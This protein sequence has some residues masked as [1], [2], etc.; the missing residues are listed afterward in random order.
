MVTLALLGDTYPSQLQANPQAMRDLEVLWAGSSLETFRAKVPSLRPQVL[1]LDFVDLGKV[2]ERLVPELLSLTGAAHA[3]VSY[4]LTHHGMLQALTSQRIRFVQ[5]PLPLSLL[6]THV[7]RAL[8]EARQ[9]RSREVPQAPSREPKPPRFTHEQ[10][11]RLL[12]VVATVKCECP[13]HL[14]QLI[15]GLRAFEE[16][17]KDCESRDEKDQR[18]HAL[19]HRQTAVAREAMED[20]LAALLE[21]E[22]IRL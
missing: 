2:P 21:Y 8:D 13:N 6:R 20:G 19:L 12:E 15:S 9:A 1:A 5:G 18:M 16:Y 7:H 3:V 14:A 4:R 11:G 22:N 17:S 10:L